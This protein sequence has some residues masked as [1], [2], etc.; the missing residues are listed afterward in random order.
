MSSNSGQL[1]FLRCARDLSGL[2]LIFVRRLW[3]G[4]S[5]RTFL[6]TLILDPSERKCISLVE[7]DAKK[8]K[9]NKFLT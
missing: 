1:T 5:S 4:E 6:S 7:S 9:T 8:K 2:S 3:R